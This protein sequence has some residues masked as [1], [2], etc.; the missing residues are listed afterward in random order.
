MTAS[1]P[2]DD[3]ASGGRPIAAIPLAHLLLMPR[4]L[5]ILSSSLYTS[6]LHGVTERESDTVSAQATG[7]EAEG[8]VIAN[9]DLLGDA[10]VQDKL[11]DGGVWTRL[12][13]TRTSLTFR[14]A[15]RVLKGGAF[16]MTGG[17]LQRV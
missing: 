8:E 4:S 9:A 10:E 15:N 5:L 7:T 16:S 1:T 2:P 6:H 13:G 11:R 14:H 17:R 12:R 3:E